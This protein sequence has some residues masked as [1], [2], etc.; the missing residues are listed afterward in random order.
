PDPQVLHR[1]RSFVEDTGVELQVVHDPT[2]AVAGV[3]AVYADVWA[4]MGEES[5]RVVRQQALAPYQ[6]TEE[7]MTLAQPGAI[8]LHCLPA[9]RDEEVAAAVIDGP[10]SVVWR[11]SANRLPTEAA[12]LLLLTRGVHA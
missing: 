1:A 8:F 7:L 6:V 5:E 3:H 9:K 2:I 11:Q 4:S 10:Q 12:L